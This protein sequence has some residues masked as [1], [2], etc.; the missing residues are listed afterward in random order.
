MSAPRATA[1]IAEDEAPQRDDL[2]AMLR[3]LWPELAIVAEC[4]DGLA[5]IEAAE[6]LRPAVAFL[7]IRMPGVS[8]IEVARVAARYGRVVFTTAYEEYALRAFEA[9]AVDYLLK[10]IRK[11]RLAEAIARIRPRLS[12]PVLA[13]M[14]R[15]LDALEAR[16]A[17][18]PSS[19]LKWIGA[20][21]GQAIKMF[22]IAEVLYFQAKDKYTR[23]VTERDEA[24]IRTPLKE[25]VR[26][27]DPEAF[28]QIHRS[29][30]VRVSAIQAVE[31]GTDG[32]FDLKVRGRTETLPVSS[33]FQSRFR[34]M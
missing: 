22:D 15:R 21:V 6:T 9:G 17:A 11:E 5:A 33:A 24:E 30:I 28:W 27:L 20:T 8:G 19:G 3:E 26:R 34:G 32:R 12:D 25:L 14:S 10:P 1:L 18:R 7:D 16:L 29:V 23:V 13:D 2:K 4:E 31:R